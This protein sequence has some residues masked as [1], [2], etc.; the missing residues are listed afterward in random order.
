MTKKD[1]AQLVA[2]VVTAYPNFD[3]FK[4]AESVKATVS[5]WTMM[6]EDVEAAL[7]ALAVKKHIATS[8]WPPSVAELRE[9]LLEIAHPDLIP[10]DKAWLAVSDLLYSAG[11]FNH[12]DL[13]RQLPP[14]VARAVEAIGWGNLWEMHRS[15]CVGGKPGMDRVAFMQQYTPMYEREKARDMTPEELTATIDSVAAALPDK[16]QKLLA[17]REQGRRDKEREYEAIA[18]WSRRAM[19]AAA[20]P[21]ALEAGEGADK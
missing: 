2:I 13:S 15:Y 18:G 4:D 20:D 6:F 11:Q 10:P 17:D 16:G 8:K 21:L 12:G 3:K 19:I 9:I 7:V 14:L 1:A 5:L